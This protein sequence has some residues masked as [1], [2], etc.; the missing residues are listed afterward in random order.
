M[1]RIQFP[2]ISNRETWEET[3][4]LTEDGAP[5]PGLDGC[6]FAFAM[7]PHGS[8]APALAG[9]QDDLLTV[10]VEASTVSWAID[11][12]PLQPGYY[13][14]GVTFTRASRTSQILVGTIEIVDGVVP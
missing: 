8:Q 1:L 13:D 4:A 12:R 9:T 6:A 11:T 2:E 14:V 5:I 7:R 3:L 10:D